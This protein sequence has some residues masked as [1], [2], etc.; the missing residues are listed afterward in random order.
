MSRSLS[1]VEAAPRQ[2]FST[3]EV[4]RTLGLT[5]ARVRA[6]VHAG[7]C[8]PSYRGHAWRFRF[9]DLVLLRTAVGLVKAKVPLPRLRR[10]LLALSKQMPMQRPLSGVRVYADGKNV[11]VRAGKTVWQPESGQVLFSFAVDELA[12]QVRK[13]TPP[14]PGVEAAKTARKPP[15]G[16]SAAACFERALYL[17]GRGDN[18]GA[19][20]AYRQAIE[21]DPQ[22]ADAHVNLGRLA[23]NRGDIEAAAHLYHLAVDLVPLDPVA[24]YNLA[25]TLE[26]KGRS[27]AAIR[28]YLR[29]I[30]LDA[31]FADAHFNLA[32][33][34]EQAGQRSQALKHLLIYK[35]LTEA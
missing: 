19:E 1:A 12:R 32:R 18:Q 6:L 22:M 2:E 15:G 16:A 7:V 5:P 11:V 20:E 17:E 30:E 9:Q 21:L 28:H 3:R 27:A 8:H 23:H 31:D 13:L 14:K 10:A 4:A 24:H 29:A 26:D 35:R 34:C 25:L 33:L